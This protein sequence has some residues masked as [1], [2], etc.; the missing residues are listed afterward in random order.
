MERIIQVI[1]SDVLQQPTVVLSL[2]GMI[3]LI[4]LRKPVEQIV[5]SVV[6][7][8]IGMTAF[9]LGLVA[10]MEA[11]DHASKLISHSMDIP[12]ELEGYGGVPIAVESEVLW[13]AASIVLLL[14]LIVNI[15]I[16]RFTRF[17]YVYL[18]AHWSLQIALGVVAALMHWGG[19][20][21]WPAILLAAVIMGF[22]QS[23]APWIAQPFMYKLTGTNDLALGHASSIG[24]AF[25]GWLGQV[26]GQK[27]KE[28]KPRSSWEDLKIPKKLSFLREIS[29]S[30]AIFMFI[31]F[32]V[33]TFVGGWDFV[34]AELSGG[35]NPVLF[36]L[37][38]GLRFAA[39]MMVL[40]FGI[41]MFISEILPAVKGITDKLAPG[42]TP[43]LDSPV[44]FQF[45]PVSLIVGYIVAQFTSFVSIWLLY[46][47]N[48]HIPVVMLTSE[49]LFGGGLAAGVG[50][51]VGGRRGAV[52]SAGLF[53]FLITFI[54]ALAWHMPGAAMPFAQAFFSWD[55]TI[56]MSYVG[57]V[58]TIFG[59]N[60]F[61]EVAT[62]PIPTWV[63]FGLGGVLLVITAF[64]VYSRLV[65]AKKPENQ[66]PV[67][68]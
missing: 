16:A 11:M 68:G 55:P 49:N 66:L 41:R 4:M 19:M 63:H 52:I 48:W 46:L 29:V 60:T 45:A 1:V 9:L 14:A 28:G 65:W 12:L 54:R 27:E 38:E 57:S 5:T 40:L 64:I 43:A 6:K 20:P 22:Y 44:F 34:R 3:G 21:F 17:K 59:F 32:F 33:M 62:G 23:V 47:A 30:V 61:N 15:C 37:F 50:N 25:C 24:V 42:A 13:S 26:F 10:M 18:T 56:L 8:F 53:G 35:Q 39:G 51:A 67:K 31:F 7:I 36:A 58:I 2:I